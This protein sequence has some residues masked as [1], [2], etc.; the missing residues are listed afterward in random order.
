MKFYLYGHIRNDTGDLFYIG[1]G[2]GT[3][4]KSQQGR[5]PYWLNVVNAHGYTSVIIEHFE[6]ETEAFE[7]EIFFIAAIGRKDLGHGPLI[8][9]SDGGEGASGAIRTEEQKKRYS[10]KTWMRTEAGKAS[11]RGDLNPSKRPDVR[12]ILSE[13]NPHR[14]PAIREKGAA[15]FRAMGI[16]HPSKSDKHRKLMRENNPAKRDEVRK[17]I[18]ESR[19]GQPSWNTGMNLGPLSNDHRLKISQASKKSWSAKKESGEPLFSPRGL[20]KIKEAA[21]QRSLRQSKGTYITPKGSYELIAEAALANGFTSAT[22]VK[23][24]V[25]YK[26]DGKSYAPKLGWSFLPKT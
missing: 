14:D 24:C 4:F 25:G 7:A 9:M 15:T 13:K 6:T 26:R 8:N 20:A 1:K 5:N 17:K 16:A 3:R 19:M 23:N 22:I 11:M 18:S 12:L 21:R 10:E 2:E